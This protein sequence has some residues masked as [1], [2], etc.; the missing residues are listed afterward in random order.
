MRVSTEDSS[1]PVPSSS[2]VF[3]V[4]RPS[5]FRN[6]FTPH[7]VPC[8]LLKK[9]KKKKKR[10][11]KGNLLYETEYPR[12]VNVKWTWTWN[13]NVNINVN[14]SVNLKF[15]I[16]IDTPTEDKY[17]I[18]PT[19]GFHVKANDN[20]VINESVILI[21]FL[22]SDLRKLCTI[23]KIFSYLGISTTCVYWERSTKKRAKRTAKNSATRSSVQAELYLLQPVEGREGVYCE[24]LLSIPAIFGNYFILNFGKYLTTDSYC[25]IDISW[26]M[27]SDRAA[28]V[29]LHV[30]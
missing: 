23:V 7:I 2:R 10:K 22:L 9:K 3:V 8:P 29:I 5:N 14:I 16:T 27:I 18:N 25:V 4:A 20:K 12:L 13:V 6:P 15:D 17:K 24:F 30:R 21:I 1:S 28:V 19:R 26:Y 11:K